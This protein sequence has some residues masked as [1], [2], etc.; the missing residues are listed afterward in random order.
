MK[1]ITYLTEEGFKFEEE[2]RIKVY[3]TDTLDDTHYQRNSLFPD[4]SDEGEEATKIKLEKKIWVVLGNP[5]YSNYS[6]NKNP[7]I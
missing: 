4:I 6:K 5:P 3:L 2:D 7:F 1:L